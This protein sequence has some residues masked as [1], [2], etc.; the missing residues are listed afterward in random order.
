M[1]INIYTL[2]MSDYRNIQILH[3]S[4]YRNMQKLYVSGYSN[5]YGRSPR[6]HT[7][8]ALQQ[9]TMAHVRYPTVTLV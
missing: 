9:E 1:K 5:M 3:V 7:I 2:H 4:G 6:N 8:S